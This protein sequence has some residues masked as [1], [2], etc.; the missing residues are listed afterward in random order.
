LAGTVG[1]HIDLTEFKKNYFANKGLGR[2]VFRDIPSLR[3]A[4]EECIERKRSLNVEDYREYYQMLDPFQD[5]QSYRRMGFLMKTLR[6]CLERAQTR[7]QAVEQTKIEYEQYLQ[8]FFPG[9]VLVS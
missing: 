5:G 9:K 4:V 6:A 7:E 2:I 1:F 8:K 3:Q